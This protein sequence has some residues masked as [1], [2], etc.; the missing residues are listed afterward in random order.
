MVVCNKCDVKHCLVHR[1]PEAHECAKLKEEVLRSQHL[2][3]SKAPSKRIVTV[4]GVKGMKNDALARK[5]AFMK[6]KQKAKGLTSI[7]QTERVYVNISIEA[8]RIGPFKIEPFHFSKEW[9]FGRCVDWL[10]TELNIKNQNNIAS[11]PKLVLGCDDRQVETYL[12]S[13]KLKEA[14]ENGTLADA[15]SL[16]LKYVQMS[17]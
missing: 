4:P 2:L 1:H 12:L 9:S 10:A 3:R 11:A 6:L 15:D 16:C 5:V 7:P 14:M 8:E 17:N 13:L